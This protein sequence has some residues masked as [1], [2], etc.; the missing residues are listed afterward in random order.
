MQKKIFLVLM[1]VVLL[2]V[3][4]SPSMAADT[5]KIA[6]IDPLSGAFAGVGDAG[7]RHF[8]Y[9]AELINAKGGVLGGKKFAIVPFDNK[10][11]PQDSLIQF[12]NAIDQ[13]IRIITQGNGSSVA[14]ALIEAVN[15]FNERNPGDEVIYLNYAAVTPAF[16]NE[17]CSFWHF[18]FDAHADMKMAAITDY[19][20]EQKNVKKVY[21]INQDYVFGHAVADA[22]KSMLKEKRPDVQIVGDVYTP[23]GKVKDFSPYVSQIKAS[24]ADTIITGNWGADMSLLVKAAK[25]AGLDAKFHTFY[26]GGLGA[27]KAI[28]EAGIGVLNHVTE[29]HI[30][31]NHEEKNKKDEEFFLGYQKKYSQNGESPYYYGRI[32]TEME[33][34]AAAV[35]KAGSTDAKAIAFALE[36]MEHET[37]YGKVTMR[38]ED[39]QLIQPLYIS[40]YAKAGTDKVKYDSENTGVGFSTVKRIEAPA[41]AMPT[42]CKME[43]PAKK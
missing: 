11:S 28:G 32:R 16:T 39:H 41:T 23:L 22:A 4:A 14:G 33:M 38:A 42:T 29:W 17:G 36:G 25:D 19:I 6:Y 34:L 21:L 1:G 24:G 9:N 35:K 8:Q 31:L 30:N 37:P 3:I 13:G 10:T 43:R 40:V 2:A 27:P 26:G 5:I 20:K 18:R 12:K 15:K 7:L